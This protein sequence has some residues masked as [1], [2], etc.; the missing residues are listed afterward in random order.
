MLFMYTWKG[1]DALGNPILISAIAATEAL[2][3]YYV[4]EQHG[5]RY[6][7]YTSVVPNSVS[8]VCDGMV[9]V[10]RADAP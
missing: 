1:K 2:A 5:G 4:T 6:I 10:R 8:T 7:E 9:D 3:R